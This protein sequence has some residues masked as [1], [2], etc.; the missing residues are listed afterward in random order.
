MAESD[1]A[2]ITFEK[3]LAFTLGPSIEGGFSNDPEDPG[4]WTGGARDKGTLKGTKFGI[5]A[6]AYPDLDIENLTRA[7]ASV[8][9]RRDYWEKV[10]GYS[11]PSPVALLVFDTAV[12][13][14][15]K[16]SIKILQRSCGAEVD[17]EFG[18]LT[19]KAVQLISLRELIETFHLNRESFYKALPE[20]PHD[21]KG[22][23]ARNDKCRDEA[24]RWAQGWV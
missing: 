18:T 17:G 9:Y 14:G 6:H 16:E 19:L 4:N 1:D 3:C 20:Y 24:M 10:H 5:S 23:L 7:D 12:N 22:W 11:L 15:C 21:G 8:I 2:L 13:S